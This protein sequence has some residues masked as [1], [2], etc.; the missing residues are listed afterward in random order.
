MST[1]TCYRP[2][3]LERAHATHLLL[4][5]FDTPVNLYNDDGEMRVSGRIAVPFL[6]SSGVDR[7]L[8]RLIWSVADPDGVGTLTVR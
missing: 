8:L 5:Y 7:S 6:T 3:P 2:T 1:P 4:T